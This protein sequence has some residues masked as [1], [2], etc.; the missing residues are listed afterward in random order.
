M[1]PLQRALADCWT[2]LR[3]AVHGIEAKPLRLWT[4]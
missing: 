1:E 2:H 4:T 3:P